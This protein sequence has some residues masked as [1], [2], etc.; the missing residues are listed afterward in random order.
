MAETNSIHEETEHEGTDDSKR[1]FL[2]YSTVAVGAVGATSAA[3]P[4]I[5]LR[6]YSI[7]RTALF[8]AFICTALYTLYID[9]DVAGRGRT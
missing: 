1:D 2:L 6:L 3:W 7:V 4:F 8:T 9:K 5:Y